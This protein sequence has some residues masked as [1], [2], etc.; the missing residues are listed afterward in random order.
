MESGLVQGSE[1]RIELFLLGGVELRGIDRKSSDRLLAQPKLTALLAFL[2]L[3]PEYRPQRRDRIVGLL[4][5]ELDQAHARTALR[6][7]VHALRTSLG[8]QA[9]RSRGDEEIGFAVPP[10][11]CDAAELAAAAESG[12]MQRAFELYRGELMPGFHLVG[13]VEFE[14]WLDDE[15]TQ[16]RERA[17]A[18]AWGLAQSLENDSRLTDAGVWARRAARYSW[19]DERILRRTLTML[20]RIGDHAGALRMFDEFAARMRQELNAE[21]SPETRKLADSLR[22]STR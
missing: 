22:P 10:V 16:A 3:S 5:P 21:P 20:A 1:K 13:C 18:S 12:R 14:R 7:A 17:G 19:D 11:W 8:T 15:R 4:W 6:K 2:A 9:L